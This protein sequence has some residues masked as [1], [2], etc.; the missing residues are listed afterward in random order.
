[1]SADKQNKKKEKK[2]IYILESSSIWNGLSQWI[3]RDSCSCLVPFTQGWTIVD[4][5]TGPGAR[6]MSRS[7]KTTTNNN[8]NNYDLLTF[9]VQHL[10]DFSTQHTHIIVC[11][12]TL[13]QNLYLILH[14][15]LST[16][17][18]WTGKNDTSKQL[19]RLKWAGSVASTHNRNV[20]W[21]A[22]GALVERAHQSCQNQKNDLAWSSLIPIVHFCNKRGF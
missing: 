2:I 9:T 21:N 17:E 14:L 4:V 12:Y 1:M 7:C 20:S 11:Y 6:V 3:D 10:A 5:E 18:T 15:V 16:N 8:N 19:N 13:E 22:V